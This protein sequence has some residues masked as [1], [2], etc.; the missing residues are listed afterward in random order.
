MVLWSR[1]QACGFE[2]KCEHVHVEGDVKACFLRVG[3]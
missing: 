1:K 2:S 3:R